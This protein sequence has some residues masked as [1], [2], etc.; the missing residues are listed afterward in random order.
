MTSTPSAGDA[1]AT[2]SRVIEVRVAELTGPWPCASTSNVP[3]GAPRNPR[4]LARRFTSISKLVRLGHD[5]HSG[6]Y[7]VEVASAC[8]SRSRSSACRWRS[9]IS[10]GISDGGFAALLQEGLLIGGWVAMWRP[11]EVFL[12]DWWPI[13]GEV[14][15]LDR[16]S[17]MP[18][19][20]EYKE[21]CQ[22]MHG[23]RTGRRSQPLGWPARNNARR[24]TVD[25]SGDLQCHSRARNIS[26]LPKKNARFERQLSIR[27]LRRLFL[28][29]IPPLR[30]RIRT[31]MRRSSASRAGERSIKRRQFGDEVSRDWRRHHVPHRSGSHAPS[32]KC[33]QRS[34]DG[35]EG[36]RL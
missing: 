15:L 7:S 4:C 2:N 20:I 24:R 34:V 30:I 17:Q 18:V 36:R 27:R 8:S 13:L 16:L 11:L 3:P 33:D 32:G 6:S 9:A 26:T 14:R 25:P 29:A 5:E 19:R 35:R 22:T 1:I 28:R 23:G 12:Y 10:S 31:I 21:R